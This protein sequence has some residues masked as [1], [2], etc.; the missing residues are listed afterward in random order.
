MAAVLKV[1]EQI[2]TRRLVSLAWLPRYKLLAME[3]KHDPNQ[4]CIFKPICYS[5]LNH[6]FKTNLFSAS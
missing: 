4:V 3:A 2:R 5:D 1:L 6:S